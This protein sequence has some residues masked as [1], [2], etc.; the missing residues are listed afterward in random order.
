MSCQLKT[1]GKTFYNNKL[2]YH[3]GPHN[4]NDNNNDNDNDNDK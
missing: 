2:E 1:S 3:K 4:D